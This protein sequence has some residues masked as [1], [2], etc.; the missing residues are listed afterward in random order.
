[1]TPV[2]EDCDECDEERAADPPGRW[3]EGEVWLVCGGRDYTDDA[4][5]CKVLNGL[6]ER[7]GFPS[8]I[9]QGGALGAD[10]LTLRWAKR[11]DIPCISQNA[12]WLSLGGN[13]APVRNQAM[14]D[15]WKPQ[16]CVA[17]P[18]GKGTADMVRRAHKAGVEVYLVGKI[19]D[20]E[21][22]A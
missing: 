12:R 10:E 18:G 22:P 20:K 21:K 5:L 9:L 16:I 11:A 14:L 19:T 7:R 17:F 4:W 2:E 6:V 3:V 13:A 15:V 1:M 8:F